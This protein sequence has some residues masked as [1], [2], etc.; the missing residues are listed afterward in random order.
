MSATTNTTALQISPFASSGC[1][2]AIL[3]CFLLGRY[4]ID[5]TTN[6]P[7]SIGRVVQGWFQNNRFQSG[8]G[9]RY[10]I[11]LSPWPKRAWDPEMNGLTVFSSSGTNFRL[12]L[13]LTNS[14]F[15]IRAFLPSAQCQSEK[16]RRYDRCK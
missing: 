9:P 14:K 8:C 2:T 11:L 6:R 1:E 4:G 7:L 5:V 10:H 16:Q 13:L 15:G 3:F 12:A